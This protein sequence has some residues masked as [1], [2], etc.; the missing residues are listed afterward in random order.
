MPGPSVFIQT[1]GSNYYYYYYQLH[2]KFTVLLFVL[3]CCFMIQP[4]N[5]QENC[6]PVRLFPFAIYSLLF[7]L[8]FI[9][10]FIFS[11]VSFFLSLCLSKTHRIASFST[12]TNTKA[13]ISQCFPLRYPEKK[14]FS[15]SDQ[16][17]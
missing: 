3:L 17:K 10:S 9:L 5:I 6:R 14:V 1:N 12:T 8:S 4:Y 13:K 16:I 11:P 15:S 2:P 7:S